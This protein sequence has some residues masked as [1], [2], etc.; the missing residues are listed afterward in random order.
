MRLT[1]GVVT[2]GSREVSRGQ[3]SWDCRA[4]RDCPERRLTRSRREPVLKSVPRYGSTVAAMRVGEV[5]ERA[6]R[7]RR[8]APL[9]RAP[10]PAARPDRAP[11]G[12]RDYDEETVRFVRAI[13]EAQAVGFTL[14][15]IDEYLRAARAAGP[16][17]EKL[18]I[19]AAAKIDEIDG[20][21]ARAAPHARRARAGRRLRV[22]LARPL[23]LRRRLPRAPRRATPARALAAPRHERRERRQHAAPDRRSAARCSRGRTCCT[24]ARCRRGAAA[25]AAAGP[26]ALP[27]RVRLGQRGGRSARRSSGATASSS[28]RSRRAHVVLWFEHDL[29]DQLQLIDALALAH[30]RSASPGADR[31][32]LVPAS[33]RSPGS[34]S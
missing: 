14:A 22:R 9:L 21:I 4:G 13:K 19:R 24:K 28:T 25:R 6:G 34:A 12:H 1:H 10:R 8:D 3:C 20:R 5:A 2:K 26:R 27:R 16:A 23:H 17:S 30:P 7:Q 31:D 29:Y 15:E 33:R 18:R 11:S 32:R